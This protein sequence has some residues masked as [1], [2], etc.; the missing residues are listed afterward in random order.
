MITAILLASALSLPEQ[1]R[2]DV[3]LRL[4][5]A[6]VAARGIEG[7][8]GLQN[9]GVW[10]FPYLVRTKPGVVGVV[11]QRFADDSALPA[12]EHKPPGLALSR[13]EGATWTL[14][15]EGGRELS[16]WQYYVTLSSGDVLSLQK[17]ASKDVPK[18][19]LPPAA[20]R[21]DHGYGGVYSVWD[22]APLPDSLKTW[23]LIRRSA[24][25]S[26]LDRVPTRVDDP[27]G[28]I[29]GFARETRPN[30]TLHGQFP[31]QIIEAKDGSLRA[32][33][34]GCRLKPDRSPYPQ[35]LSWCLSSDDQGQTWKFLS[36][37]GPSEGLPLAGFHEPSLTQLP[38][39]S[40]LA[41]LR[42]D[43][44]QYGGLHLSRST[45]GG[46]MWSK[47]RKVFPFGVLPR[48]LTL[49]NGVTVLAFGRPGT[50]L[51]FSKDGK[52]ETWEGLTP[53]VTE[54]LR[55]LSLDGSPVDFSKADDPKASH[56]QTRTSGYTDFLPLGKDSFLVAYDQFDVPDAAGVPRKTILVRRVTVR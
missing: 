41:A 14:D 11:F 48:L 22:P 4:D 13:D 26:S 38:D 52:G 29:L 49:P 34:Y 8:K 21:V 39:G 16:D 35:F 46:T 42:S 44:A 2:R 28:G 43:V 30:V 37:I 45:D 36:V 54:S 24:R 23:S 55:G 32:A 12:S 20:G 56:P 27:D 18:T 40:L 6:V 1:D 31:M 17:P 7:K 50:H 53:L 10:Q 9:W 51:V 3:S 19:S 47:P 33:V 25:G 15:E 5:E